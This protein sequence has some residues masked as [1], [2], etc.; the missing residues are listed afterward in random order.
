M[1]FCLKIQAS[2]K[3]EQNRSVSISMFV[4]AFVYYNKGY[5]Y[6]HISICLTILLSAQVTSNRIFSKLNICFS[7]TTLLPPYYLVYVKK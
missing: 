7:Y 1:T 4:L 6:I 5:I 2:C 3:F